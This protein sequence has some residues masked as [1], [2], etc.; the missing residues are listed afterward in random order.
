MTGNG[1]FPAIP[2][3]A[4]VDPV[5]GTLRDEQLSGGPGLP[6][7]FVPLTDRF[8]HPHAAELAREGQPVNLIRDQLGHRS[9]ATTGRYLRDITPEERLTALRQRGVEAVKLM[10]ISLSHN[11]YTLGAEET[12]RRR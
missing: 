6:G 2:R 3:T 10:Y 7:L 12:R 4:L 9:L 5:A 11:G 8:R 1:N